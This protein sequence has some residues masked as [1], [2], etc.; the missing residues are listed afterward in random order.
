MNALI[1]T[2]GDILGGIR[3]ER[4]VFLV[5]PCCSPEPSAL[6]LG[7]LQPTPGHAAHAATPASPDL[8]TDIEGV[9]GLLVPQLQVEDIRRL[10][11]MPEPQGHSQDDASGQLGKKQREAGITH[12][13]SCTGPGAAVFRQEQKACFSFFCTFLF[14]PFA[15][16]NILPNRRPTP[17]TCFAARTTQA[18]RSSPLYQKTPHSGAAQSPFQFLQVVSFPKAIL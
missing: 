10:R 9:G 14:T 7:T 13:S 15:D 17:A 12:C 8:L 5:R 16:K 3:G 11:V 6:L 1:G 4:E 18:T 2:A